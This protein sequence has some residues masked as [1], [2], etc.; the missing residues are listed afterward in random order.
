MIIQLKIYMPG[1]I[2]LIQCIQIIRTFVAISIRLP[3]RSIN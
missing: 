3:I 2:F 1:D